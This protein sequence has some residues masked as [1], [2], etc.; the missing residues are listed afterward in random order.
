M[1]PDLKTPQDASM[2][3]LVSG[4]IHDAQELVHQQFEL[5]KHEVRND[6]R[7]TKEAGLA[8][9]AGACL[10][11]V[12]ALLLA[13]MLV[14]LLYWAVPAVPE[15]GWYGICGFAICAVA[16]CLVYTSKLKL[17]A[18]H[19]LNDDS[20]QALKENVQWITNRK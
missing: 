5:F 12:G 11:L 14:K 15:W 4:I 18:I 13:E 3:A 20:A 10:G 1:S 19:P 6:L 2:T 8:L 7:K 9:G 17:D 16:G